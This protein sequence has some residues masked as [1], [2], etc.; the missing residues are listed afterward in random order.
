MLEQN[1]L[2]EMKKL[3]GTEINESDI[4]SDKTLRAEARLADS[5]AN[6]ISSIKFIKFDVER[7]PYN[8]NYNDVAGDAEKKDRD[9]IPNIQKLYL[10][11]KL[12]MKLVDEVI[13]KYLGSGKS[14]TMED[15][16]DDE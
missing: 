7:R 12:E 1:I 16:D 9:S 11:A 8:S 14:S 4:S 13:E 3:S 5:F 10:K 6:L 15:D 2:N